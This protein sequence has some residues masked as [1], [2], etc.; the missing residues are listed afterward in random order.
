[1]ILTDM[2]FFK[3]NTAS[4]SV[5]IRVLIALLG[6]FLLANLVGI[7][8]TYLPAENKVDGIVTG[9]MASFIVYLVVVLFVFSTQ[10]VLRALLGVFSTC[11]V[12]F[13][14]ITYIDRVVQ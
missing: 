5:I 8:I 12:T 9:L 13:S 7:L 6:G 4:I 10:T 3:D 14:L 1:M 11:V 2:T